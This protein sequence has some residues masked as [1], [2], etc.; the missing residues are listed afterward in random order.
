MHFVSHL[1]ALSVAR[2]IM[3]SWPGVYSL[4]AHLSVDVIGI[5]GRALSMATRACGVACGFD[6]GARCVERHPVGPRGVSHRGFVIANK[7]R[8]RVDLYLRSR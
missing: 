6:F 8:Q 2:A 1:A 5:S 4:R 3:E 7:F